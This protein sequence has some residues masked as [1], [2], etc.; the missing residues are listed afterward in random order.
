MKKCSRKLVAFASTGRNA[1]D[2]RERRV[3]TLSSHLQVSRRRFPNRSRILRLAR[4]RQAII[5]LSLLR[6]HTSS[7]PLLQQPSIS[8]DHTTATPDKF[9]SCSPSPSLAVFRPNRHSR[10]RDSYRSSTVVISGSWDTQTRRRLFGRAGR[11]HCALRGS[12]KIHPPEPKLP[13][14]GHPLQD[15]CHS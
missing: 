15:V 14:S 6:M 13:M 4:S 8:S 9:P 3:P 12:C 11:T 5:T 1:P 10:R 2:S 7:I